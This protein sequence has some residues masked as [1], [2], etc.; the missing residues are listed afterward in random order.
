MTVPSPTLDACC[1]KGRCT[2][3]TLSSCEDSAERIIPETTT[4]TPAA[5]KL[6]PTSSLRLCARFA[7]IRAPSS[8]LS[9]SFT[10][11][12]RTSIFL[13]MALIRSAGIPRK[14]TT[15]KLVPQLFT[16]IWTGITLSTPLIFLISSL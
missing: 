12:F 8:L 11:P 15:S 6:S 7:P 13:E 14:T 5:S 4:V 9:H 16:T 3:A 1:R 10:D 2:Y